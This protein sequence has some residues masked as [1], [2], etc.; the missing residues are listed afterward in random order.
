MSQWNTGV[1]VKFK[2][3]TLIN[4]NSAGF[5]PF[6]EYAGSYALYNYKLNDPKSGITYSN[7]NLVRAFEH[8][9]DHDSS[10]AGF[11]LVHV[12]MVKH[13]GE[14]VSGAVDALSAC[15]QKDRNGFNLSLQAVVHA[16][17]KVNNVMGSMLCTQPIIRKS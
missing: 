9:L 12:D 16:M 1:A 5:K 8:G 4:Q 2:T 11:V 17:M 13:S 7:L 15:G 14:L 3:L 10:E 6:M